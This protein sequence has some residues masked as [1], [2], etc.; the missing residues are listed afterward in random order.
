MTKVDRKIASRLTIM[1][2]SPKG[3]GSKMRA[4]PRA[5]RFTAIHPPNHATWMTTNRML[6]ANAVIASAIRFGVVCSRAR[7]TCSGGMWAFRC[8]S[9]PAEG[10]SVGWVSGFELMPLSSLRLRS[11]RP[12]AGLP[13]GPESWGHGRRRPEGA[14]KPAVG[15][16]GRT[17][18]S[19]RCGAP[20][21][22]GGVVEV[23]CPGGEDERQD[24]VDDAEQA[25]HRGQRQRADVRRNPLA[26][27][28]V[29][30]APSPTPGL[31]LPTAGRAP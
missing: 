14:G 23:A 18:D 5:P 31:P 6:P 3:Y 4:L 21:A 26:R 7:T 20:S 24:A 27:R 12:A 2:S 28:P 16:R 19:S 13:H 1:V 9:A 29:R 22:G 10:A 25:E 17:A 8:R 30:R 11:V 15:A